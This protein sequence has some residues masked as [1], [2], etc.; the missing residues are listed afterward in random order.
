MASYDLLLF[1]LKI[2]TSTGG[3]NSMPFCVFRRDHLWSTS[4]IICS[5]GS[6][7]FAVQFGDHFRFGNHLRPGIIC[8]AVHWVLY[9]SFRK[10][11]LLN[12]KK[13]ELNIPFGLNEICGIWTVHFKQ[14]EFL[15]LKAIIF[16]SEISIS[17]LFCI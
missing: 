4:R 17:S 8:G 13:R 11:K 7:S 6:G 3:T 2:E 5:C 15:I 12:T 10:S 14:L 9:F 1:M 16:I